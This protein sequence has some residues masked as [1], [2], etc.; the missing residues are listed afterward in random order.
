[1]SP[2]R[3][4][5]RMICIRG[6]TLL[7]TSKKRSVFICQWRARVV[8]SKYEKSS[9][10]IPQKWRTWSQ[11]GNKCCAVRSPLPTLRTEAET[12]WRATE[13]FTARSVLIPLDLHS[14]LKRRPYTPAVPVGGDG[15]LHNNNN[16]NNISKARHFYLCSTF[17]PQGN[18]KCFT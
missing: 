13:G 14:Y 10:S 3:S 8:V 18:S 6:K 16:D 11:W 4:A 7:H 15:V 5:G 1:M 12:P 9:R 17:Q 2:L